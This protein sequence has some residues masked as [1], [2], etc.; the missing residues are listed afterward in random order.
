M[1]A[2]EPNEILDGMP[3]EEAFI[4]LGE[5]VQG[6]ETGG[7]PLD[8]ATR[9]YEEGMALAQVCGRLLNRAELKVT[10]LKNAYA[11]FLAEPSLE[12]EE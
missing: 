7:L 5:V 6:L 9:L 8:E 4:R 3:F 12:Q 10:E 1:S 2:Q 11:D